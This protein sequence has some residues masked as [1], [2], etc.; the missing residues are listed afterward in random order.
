M[1]PGAE[2]QSE[3]EKVGTVYKGKGELMPDILSNLDLKVHVTSILLLIM[4]EYGLSTLAELVNTSQLFR[5]TVFA[6]FL[7]L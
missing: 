6:V 5:L 7:I 1:R 2:G 3:Q 4:N